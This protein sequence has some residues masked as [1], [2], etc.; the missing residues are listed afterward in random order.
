MSTLIWSKSKLNIYL[1]WQEKLIF[2]S[3]GLPSAE[4]ATLLSPE[5]SSIP[6]RLPWRYRL[7]HRTI[8]TAFIAAHAAIATQFEYFCRAEKYHERESS[9]ASIQNILEINAKRQFYFEWHIWACRHDYSDMKYVYLSR[10]V[11]ILLA[12][13][14]SSWF[15]HHCNERK[16]CIALILKHRQI[17]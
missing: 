16:N 2:F 3:N 12:H 13:N 5:Y 15:Y 10:S 1:N 17:L 7:K 9:I 14:A 11:S 8:G 6:S 4:A